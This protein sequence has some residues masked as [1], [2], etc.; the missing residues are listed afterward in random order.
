MKDILI[1]WTTQEARKLIDETGE[2]I[3]R[4]L[5]ALNKPLEVL[6]KVISSS[7]NP[8]K[9]VD[10][11]MGKREHN[12]ASVL[13]SNADDQNLITRTTLESAIVGAAR[14]AAPDCE[15]LVGVV[16]QRTT[17]K[18]RFDANWALRGVKFGKANREETNEAMAVIVERMQREFRLSDDD[19]DFTAADA[20]RRRWVGKQRRR[21]KP[22]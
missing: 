22:K 20:A 16:V 3:A 14:K 21:I 19:S 7:P 6:V 10:L 5:D 2:P 1:D 8:T 9:L 18:S 11:T 12:T 4:E 15:S 13:I 17:P